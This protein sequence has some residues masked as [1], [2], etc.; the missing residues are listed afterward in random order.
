[1]PVSV[2]KLFRGCISGS[3]LTEEYISKKRTDSRS[4][5]ALQKQQDIAI[6]ETTPASLLLCQ[7]IRPELSSKRSAMPRLKG[8]CRR[9]EVSGLI[10]SF[11]PLI[12]K[13]EPVLKIQLQKRSPKRPLPQ[14]WDCRQHFLIQTPHKGQ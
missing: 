7:T 2:Q 9:A 3:Q 10:C 4:Q 14:K 5:L 1:M 6:S 12:S 8:S 11:S 13:Q